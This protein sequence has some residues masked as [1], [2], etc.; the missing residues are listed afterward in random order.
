MTELTG[1][2][3]VGLSET[4]AVRTASDSG[5]DRVAEPHVRTGSGSDR[6]AP[7]PELNEDG[8]PHVSTACSSGRGSSE[9]PTS[10][11]QSSC[12]SELESWRLYGNK[13]FASAITSQ[14]ALTLA[15]PEGN[16]SGGRGLA[17]FS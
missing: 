4:R 5:S 11:V 12:D 13:W 10:N 14:I 17:L 16:P 8:E 3:D 7:S 9:S 1:G 6:V 15:R 2:S